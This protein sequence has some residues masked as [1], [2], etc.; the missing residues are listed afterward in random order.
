[1]AAEQT[2]TKKHDSGTLRFKDGP[3]LTPKVE[4]IMLH[5]ARKKAPEW[6]A[7]LYDVPESFVHYVARKTGFPAS[8]HG[9][10][11][12]KIPT[13][14]ATAHGDHTLLV[15]GEDLSADW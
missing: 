1:M 5:I 11:A 4:R 14:L 12:A 8:A 9:K 15:T 6:I 2:T 3:Y 13:D 10:D 7:A